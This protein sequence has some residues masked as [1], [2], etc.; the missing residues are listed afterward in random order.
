MEY[1]VF[2]FAVW[3][4]KRVNQNKLNESRQKV[5]DDLGSDQKL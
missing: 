3:R 5:E 2:C 4:S 1:S